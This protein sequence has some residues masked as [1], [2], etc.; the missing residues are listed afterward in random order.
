MQ[1]Y[2]ISEP[3][4]RA[5]VRAGFQNL[6]RTVAGLAGVTPEETWDFFSYGMLLN[7]T[8]ALEFPR[9]AWE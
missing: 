8:A 3:E 7:V 5:H 1:A 9:E 2:T 4:I 6:V